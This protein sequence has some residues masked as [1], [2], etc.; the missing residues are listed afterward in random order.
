[1]DLPLAKMLIVNQFLD[2]KLVWLMKRGSDLPGG[3]S[4]LGDT[5]RVIDRDGSDLGMMIVA[6]AQHCAA[7]QN[8]ELFVVSD[9]YE[10]TVVHIVQRR[11]IGGPE[12]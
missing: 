7:R 10:D 9:P 6:A 2:V 4:N 3:L 11:E 5:V 1:M 12:A 8:A